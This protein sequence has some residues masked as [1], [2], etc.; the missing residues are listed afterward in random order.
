MS[1]TTVAEIV[2]R[3]VSDISALAPSSSTDKAF[4]RSP[5]RYRLR[6]WAIESGSAAFRK[7]EIARSGAEED[8]G[9]WSPDTM[10]R[11][12]QLEI[13]VAY[14][15]LPGLYRTGTV[16]DDFQDMDEVMDEDARLICDAV[17]SPVNKASIAHLY[18]FPKVEAPDTQDENV[19][20]QT[21]TVEVRFYREF[22]S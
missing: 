7:F 16:P 20:F 10:E 18:S 4:A 22:N 11:V 3:M 5:K 15:V 13:T 2:D 1:T 21:I 12:A 14:P 6:E 9:V 8:V 19:W 17:M